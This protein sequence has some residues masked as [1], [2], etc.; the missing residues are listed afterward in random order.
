M[1]AFILNNIVWGFG[2]SKPECL[3]DAIQ[4]LY[5]HDKDEIAERL[6]NFELIENIYHI[7]KEE[8]KLH[9]KIIKYNKMNFFKGKEIELKTYLRYG[10]AYIDIDEDLREEILNNY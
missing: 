4:W 3:A 10:I 5:E 8:V 1:Y 6:N 7:S 2:K 9:E